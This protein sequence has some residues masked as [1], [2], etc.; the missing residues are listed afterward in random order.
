MSHRLAVATMVASTLLW[1]MAGVVT[2]HLE[3]ARSFE[4]TFW[5]SFFSAVALLVL[6]PALR[7]G[8]RPVRDAVLEGGRTLWLSGLC[9]T[10]MFIAF[11]LALT[12]TRVANVLVTMAIAPLLTALIAHFV[13]HHRLAART[14]SAI[15]VAGVG[16]GWMYARELVAADA[17]QLLGSLVALGVPIA[18]AINWTVIQ[19]SRARPGQD[20]LPA[21]LIGAV[22]AAAITLPLALPFSGSAHD[23]AL[24]ALL[25]VAQLAVPCLMAVAAGRALSA[26]E[27]S[28][29]ALLEIVFGVAWPWLAGREAPAPHVLGGGL[30]VIAA[31]AGNETLA[32]RR[33]RR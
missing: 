25:G 24:L 15:V 32:L 2:L 9:W 21:V 4:V 18:A 28:L 23:V 6:L 31:L 10:V 8:A 33:G 26:P 16:I 29:L 11:M 13:L 19:A 17:R 22:L 1:S 3:N 5:R 20:L 30:L 7:G 12:L 14:W 27:A